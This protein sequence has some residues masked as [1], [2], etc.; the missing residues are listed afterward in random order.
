MKIWK[1]KESPTIELSRRMAS[2]WD[3]RARK[4][5]EYYIATGFKHWDLEAF[6]ASG[7]DAAQRFILDDLGNITRADPKTLSILELGCGIGRV[8]RAFA[9][10][11]GHV[12]AVDVSAEMIARAKRLLSDQDNVTLHLNN[13]LDLAAIPGESI[14]FAFSHLVFQHIPSAAVVENYVREVYRVLRPGSLFKFQ[15]QGAP[16][17]LDQADTWVGVTLDETACRRLAE[18]S[19]FEMR[20]VTGPGTEECWL[21]F[22]K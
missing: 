19:G 14:D 17:D 9:Q 16:T 22:F 6:L 1:E 10:I 12:H 7:R 2:D 20:Y 21:W 3:K 18:M 15:V 8:T 11:F 13:G 5:A 4:N